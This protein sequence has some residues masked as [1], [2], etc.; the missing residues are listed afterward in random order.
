MS[1]HDVD[2]NPAEEGALRAALATIVDSIDTHPDLVDLR[3]RIE[4]GGAVPAPVTVLRPARARGLRRPAAVAAAVAAAAAVLAGTVALVA[5]DGGDGAVESRV[6]GQVDGA[7]VAVLD[8]P[9]E[10]FSVE[11]DDYRDWF[12]W[13]RLLVLEGDDGSPQALMGVSES[14]I[15]P[16]EGVWAGVEMS[17][18]PPDPLAST[19]VLDGIT[20]SYSDAVSAA[21]A[22][23]TAMWEL[24][25]AAGK[26]RRIAVELTGGDLDEEQVLSLLAEVV[27]EPRSATPS[28]WEVVPGGEFLDGSPQGELYY[29]EPGGDGVFR[30]WTRPGPLADLRRAWELVTQVA[31]TGRTLRPIELD[32]RPA[33]V[34]EDSTRRTSSLAWEVDGLVVV[35]EG[36]GLELLL[37]LAPRVRL[38]PF[39]EAMEVI[40]AGG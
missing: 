32:G 29:F 26:H 35:I 14:A 27:H 1:R 34:V 17:E 39:D 37:E 31:G 19:V 23:W 16:G 24:P 33:V 21:G 30:T 40:A 13:Y 36:A 38:L 18:E 8:P 4:H 6:A 28:G 7:M 20:V 12:R 22:A 9:P 3:D 11:F 2:P 10:G 15:V 25:G 5:P